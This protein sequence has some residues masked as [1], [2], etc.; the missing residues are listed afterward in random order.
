MVNGETTIIR[1]LFDSNGFELFVRRPQLLSQLKEY[2]TEELKDVLNQPTIRLLLATARVTVEK[3]YTNSEVLARA[4]ITSADQYY[5]VYEI[6]DPG[7]LNT[8]DRTMAT[9]YTQ[10]ILPKYVAFFPKEKIFKGIDYS[11]CTDE[12]I[13]IYIFALT[14]KI[15]RKICLQSLFN[16]ISE[17]I[18]SKSRNSKL[19]HPN[20]SII[21]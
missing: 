9:Q 14:F 20:Y 16:D 13:F 7:H 15:T 1:A 10:R 17:N 3:C 8:N 18:C 5:D 6:A 4:C 11:R 19:L 12:V 2:A 21:F